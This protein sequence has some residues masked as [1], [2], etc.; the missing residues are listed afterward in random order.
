MNFCEL[1]E[2]WA[3]FAHYALLHVQVSQPLERFDFFRR[4]LRDALVNSDGLRQETVADKDLRQ[5][6]KIF[7]GPEGF[8]LANVQLADGH[9]RDLIL[10]LVLQNML[11]FRNGL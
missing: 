10:R 6:F 3:R 7:D 1:E 5:T 11:V 4:Q 8:S 2:Q 9:Q